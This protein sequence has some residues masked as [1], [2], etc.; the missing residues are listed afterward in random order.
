MIPFARAGFAWI[1]PTV[2]GAAI[3]LAWARSSRHNTP[4]TD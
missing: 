4:L 1:I 2:L 3:G